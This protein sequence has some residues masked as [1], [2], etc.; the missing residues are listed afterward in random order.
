MKKKHIVLTIFGVLLALIIL[1]FFLPGSECDNMR[2]P[3]FEKKCDC[4]GVKKCVGGCIINPTT[5]CI[6]FRMNCY[7][8][9]YPIYV[10]NSIK[11]QS[12]VPIEN[13][14]SCN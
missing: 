14:V 4:L 12:N 8:I 7:N 6:G 10:E 5:V 2:G 1:Y 3:K 13:E 11:I 9:T